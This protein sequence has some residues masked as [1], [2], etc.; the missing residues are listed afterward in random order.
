MNINKII[1]KYDE[2]IN[3]MHFHSSIQIFD[4]ERIVIEYCKSIN[5]I[6]ENE[7]R[8]NLVKHILIIAGLN[9]KMSN[10]NKN[11]IIINGKI[12]S[13]NFEEYGRREK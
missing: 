12:H 9:L 11:G 10:Y 1:N 6:N 2:Y 5:V 3:N 4:N 7:I 13:L 8:L